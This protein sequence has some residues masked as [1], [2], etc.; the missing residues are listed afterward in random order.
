MEYMEGMWTEGKMTALV[1][2]FKASKAKKILLKTELEVAVRF[3]NDLVDR[4]RNSVNDLVTATLRYRETEFELQEATQFA[5]VASGDL[6]AVTQVADLLNGEI[7]S[8]SHDSARLTADLLEE[9]NTCDRVECE[10]REYLRTLLAL[11]E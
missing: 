11:S 9:C 6:Q 5:L 3:V 7:A 8:H 1:E 2:A 4:Q 10:I